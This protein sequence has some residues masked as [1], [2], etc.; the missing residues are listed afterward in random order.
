MIIDFSQ[1][2]GKTI[3]LYNDCP[4]A[5]PAG[6]SRLD[7]YTDD[8]DQTSTGGTTTTLPG[9]GPDTRTIMV[10]HVAAATPAGLRTSVEKMPW[11]IASK[12]RVW[13]RRWQ[14]FADFG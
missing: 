12:K 6:D 1:F 9:Y 14:Q 3:V 13:Q 5:I 10:F 11:P 7:Y 2:A 8:V 4:A